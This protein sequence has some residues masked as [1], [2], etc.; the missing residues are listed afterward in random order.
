[1]VTDFYVLHRHQNKFGAQPS[2]FS[3]AGN[4]FLF[5]FGDEEAGA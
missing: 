5:F 1:V 2:F 3:Q 4:W